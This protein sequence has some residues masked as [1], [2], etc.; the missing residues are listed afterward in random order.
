MVAALAC[1]LACICVFAGAFCSKTLLSTAY[2]V[3]IS[4]GGLFMAGSGLSSSRK[5]LKV[6]LVAARLIA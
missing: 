2:A 5:G 3:D 4:M 6:A 1:I